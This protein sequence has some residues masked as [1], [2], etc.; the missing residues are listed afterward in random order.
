MPSLTQIAQYSRKAIKYGSIGLLLLVILKLSYNIFINYWEKTHPKPPPPPTV[1]FDKLPAIK[2]PQA[3]ESLTLEYQLETSI[4]ELPDLGT[5]NKVF[6][7]FDKKPSLLA[8]EKAKKQAAKLGFTDKAKIINEETLVWN[9]Q[10]QANQTLEMN[11]YSGAFTLNFDWQN[12]KEEIINT[13]ALEKQQAINQAKNFL[14]QFSEE[15]SSKLEESRFEAD[16]G[17]IKGLTILPA[18]SLSEA[19]VTQV[20][21]FR[22]NIEEIPVITASPQKGIVHLIFSGINSV[23]QRMM[24]IEFNYFPVSLEQSATYPIK[25]TADAWEELKTNQAFISSWKPLE[26]NKQKAVIRKIYLAFYD[27]WEPQKYLQPVFVFEGD[28]DFQAL[29]PAIT[30]EWLAIDDEQI[31]NQ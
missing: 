24:E 19:D 9:K 1:S 8:E 30:N 17:Q 11:I 23:S 5:Q 25:S 16:Y 2:F 7:S 10:T 15:K 13:P 12:Y 21:V 26:E 3:E 29:L 28:D 6:L 14:K 22:Q 4:G 20:N 27:S 18:L 31:S